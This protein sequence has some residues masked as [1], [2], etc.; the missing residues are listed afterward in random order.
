ML[1]FLSLIYKPLPIQTRRPVFRI[2][3]DLRIIH[4]SIFEKLLIVAK[5]VGYNLM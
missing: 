4:V 1:I 2:I 3:F 5:F